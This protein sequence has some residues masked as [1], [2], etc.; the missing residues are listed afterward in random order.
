[1]SRLFLTLNVTVKDGERAI[2]M[3][4]VRF[5]RVLDPGRYRLRRL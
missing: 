4:D 5:E 1:M 3:R 2:L